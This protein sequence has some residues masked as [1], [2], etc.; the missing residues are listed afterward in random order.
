[1]LRE[2]RAP[3]EQHLELTALAAHERG[4]EALLALDLG[5]Q[6]GGAGKIVSHHAVADLECHGALPRD[7]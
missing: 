2:Q 4:V 7:A 5:R 6:T 3:I 1:M